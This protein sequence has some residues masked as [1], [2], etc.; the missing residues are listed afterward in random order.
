M[1][2]M[3]FGNDLIG[4]VLDA[5][6]L[7]IQVSYKQREFCSSVQEPPYFTVK[8]GTKVMFSDAEKIEHFKFK[9]GVGE[10][11]RT[12]FSDFISDGRKYN[13]VFE[14]YIWVEEETG[15]LRCEFLPINEGKSDLVSVA[16][17]SPIDMQPSQEGYTVLPIMQG[18]IIPDMSEQETKA[19]LSRRMFSRECSMPW[20]GQVC[21]EKG[22]MAI[23]ETPWDAEYDYYHA[24]KSKTRVG[25]NWIGSLGKIQYRRKLTLRFFIDCNYVVFCK[26]YREY[27][28][29]K[30]ALVS[31]EEKI[32]KNPKVGELIGIPVIHTDTVHWNCEPESVYYDENNPEANYRVQSFDNV[33]RRIESIKGLGVDKA[34]VHIDGWGKSG[35][36]NLHPDIIPPSEPAGGVLGMRDML[37][38]I[39]DLGYIPALHDQYRD[40]YL[41]AETYN[42]NQAVLLA[43]GTIDTCAIW[44]GGKQAM[45][46]AQLAPDYVMRNYN[47]LERLGLKPDGAYL[48]VFSVVELDEC[49]NYMHTMTRKECMEKRCECFEIIRSKG[50]IISS[51]EPIDLFAS[52]L[53]L[54]H[55]GPYAYAIWE[56]NNVEP[57]GIPIPLFNLV[58]HD[59]LLMPWSMGKRS[60]GLPKNHDGMLHALLNGGMPYLSMSPDQRE[61]DR[62]EV[63]LR[64]HAVVAKSEMVSHSFVDDR[65]SC[66]ET[67]FACGTRVSVDFD[68]GDYVI[69][70]PDQSTVEGSI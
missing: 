7:G 5:T 68:S 21:N 25:I 36:D 69:T 42:E 19:S 61:L 13:A 14:T 48:D 33:A 24:P 45:L 15:D 49:A 30:G 28:R 46:C 54:V 10:G 60:W 20:W 9:T 50:M 57:F 31:I 1:S 12:R 6:S 38:R 53:D 17:P 59:C 63:V 58:Y 2:K 37:E 51:E 40:Y 8:D 16:W 11:V 3:Y 27:L 18:L 52:H 47:R 65:Y 55:H 23:V 62:V 4:V 32:V 56:A 43:D 29:S 35:Y 44:P 64:L 41:K 39:G 67:Q 34:Y 22:Y 70:W 66:Q 26:E